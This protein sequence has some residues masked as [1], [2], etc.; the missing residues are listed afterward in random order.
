MKSS[1]DI[2]QRGAARAAAFE[3]STHVSIQIIPKPAVRRTL[4][5]SLSINPA[6]NHICAFVGAVHEP[7]L[8]QS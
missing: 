3:W 2:E 7:P 8:H 6:D 5:L 4:C 1:R